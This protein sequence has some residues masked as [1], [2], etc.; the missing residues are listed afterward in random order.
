MNIESLNSLFGYSLF[1]RWCGGFSNTNVTAHPS[2]ERALQLSPLLSGYF[3]FQLTKGGIRLG[4]QPLESVWLESMRLS[5]AFISPQRLTLCFSGVN[6]KQLQVK[7]ISVG[8]YLTTPKYLEVREH[9]LSI[10]KAATLDVLLV[11][12]DDNIISNTDGQILGHAPIEVDDRGLLMIKWI[13]PQEEMRAITDVHGE[14]T[15]V[16]A[17]KRRYHI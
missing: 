2:H 4:V 12:V 11:K 8:I 15:A 13:E 1:L 9:L 17:D 10:C 7:P 3:A 6:D 5:A 14:V 16:V